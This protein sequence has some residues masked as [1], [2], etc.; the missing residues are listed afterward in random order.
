MAVHWGGRGPGHMSRWTPR[1][2]AVYDF[3]QAALPAGATYTGNGG[4]GTRV[5]SS[6][7]MVASV[8]DVARFDYTSA[9]ASKGVL[10]EPAATNLALRTRTME[11]AAWT[12]IN[13]TK[14]TSAVL[15]RDGT[16]FF[17][18]FTATSA[19]GRLVFTGSGFVISPGTHT[20]A[21]DL[22]ADTASMGGV[23]GVVAGGSGGCGAIINLATGA[24]VS[25][26]A[27]AVSCITHDVG[28]GVW[29]V[30]L[31]VLAGAG[32]THINP[33]FGVSNGSTY[34]STIYPSATSGVILGTFAQLETGASG[35]SPIHT[36]ASTV[37]RTAD[38][39]AFTP[40]GSF[41]IVTF[42]DGTSQTIAGLTPG[43]PYTLT[44][45]LNSP[46]VIRISA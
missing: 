21:F 6:G 16:T 32:A 17:Q 18:Q 46:H 45:T 2:L 26:T 4:L 36:V 1:P 23:V 35:T 43:S 44:T 38:A 33:G 41:A 22:K 27:A 12:P 30:L 20:L 15:S 42:Y 40:R 39:L 19:G 10:I 7:I 9:G 14:A 25:T 37:T 28:N 29:R 5:N 24:V 34:T 8:A 3:T 11:N 31:T 13:G